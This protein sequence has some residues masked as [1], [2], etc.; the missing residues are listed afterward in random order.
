MQE[1]NERSMKQT[2]RP[3]QL[4]QCNNYHV[5][6]RTNF[7][8]CSCFLTLC[9]LEAKEGIKVDDASN[10]FV[11][12]EYSVNLGEP[13]FQRLQPLLFKLRKGVKDPGPCERQELF[14]ETKQNIFVFTSSAIWSLMSPSLPRL[15]SFYPS[16]IASPT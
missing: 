16:S 4:T 13:I 11:K 6:E 10:T 1:T 9:N 15:I 8:R 3:K 5:T 2:K 12:V 14:L 7:P